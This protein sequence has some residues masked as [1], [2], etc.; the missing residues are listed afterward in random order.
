MKSRMLSGR[1]I[2]IAIASLALSLVGSLLIAVATVDLRS[3]L[4]RAASA[5]L[6]RATHV[7][8]LQIEWGRHITVEARDIRV[9]NPTWAREPWFAQIGRLSAVVDPLSLL[10]GVVRYEKLRLNDVVLFLERGVDSDATWKVGGQGAKSQGGLAGGQGAKSQGGL[11]LIPGNRS[12]FPTLLDFVVENGRIVYRNAQKNEMEIGIAHGTIASATENTPVLLVVDGTYNGVA[13][14]VTGSDMDS[15]QALRDASKPYKGS[16]DLIAERM[17]LHFQGTFTEPLDFDGVKGTVEIDT[18]SLDAALKVFGVAKSPPIPF[19]IAGALQ[20]QGDLWQIDSASGRLSAN[21]F[22]GNLVLK[23]GKRGEADRLHLKVDFP[24]LDMAPMLTTGDAKSDVAE[25]PG[26]FVEGEVRA[27][28]LTWG[29]LRL[30]DAVLQGKT[31]PRDSKKGKLTFVFYGGKVEAQMETI[32]ADGNRIALNAS[33]TEADFSRVAALLGVTGGRV[34]GKLAAHLNLHLSNSGLDGALATARGQAVMAVTTGSIASE[35]LEE[36]SNDLF[37]LFR[38]KQGRVPVT[39]LFG[40]GTL[41]DGIVLLGPL[42][43]R[44][45]GVAVSGSGRVDLL[46]RQM[47]IVLQPRSGGTFA[48]DRPLSIEGS[49][50][51]PSIGLFR[52]STV[53]IQETPPLAPSLQAWAATVSC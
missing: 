20:R 21:P 44:A 18:A 12:Q 39:C 10:R 30:S 41:K 2:V 35:I 5:S 26:M 48:L 28:H 43:L 29:K 24:T 7:G 23:E 49:L 4:E 6:G 52:G 14:R 27:E 16:V 1:A 36:A 22:S 9:A 8:S 34:T 33:V 3:W 53:R 17:G 50:T 25:E 42:H 31:G 40:V 51:K 46:R 13:A 11:A 19:K 15:F 38:K 45:S 32:E 37:T 47:G